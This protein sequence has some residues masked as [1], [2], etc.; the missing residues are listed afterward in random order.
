MLSLAKT[1]IKVIETDASR[2]L[3]YNVLRG[4]GDLHLTHAER[5]MSLTSQATGSTCP[6]PNGK[7]QHVV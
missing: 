3:K 7:V 2:Q 1:G 6:Q 4:I 5:S